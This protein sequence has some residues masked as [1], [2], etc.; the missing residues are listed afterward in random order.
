MVIR[1]S[2]LFHDRFQLCDEL[3]AAYSCIYLQIMMFGRFTLCSMG[4]LS[5]RI[6]VF[7]GS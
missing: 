2:C 3:Y 7:V 6:C 5:R 1:S 4:F